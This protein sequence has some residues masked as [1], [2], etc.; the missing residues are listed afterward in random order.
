MSGTRLS[1]RVIWLIFSDVAIIYGGIMLA[2]YLRLGFT[3]S[4]FQLN[5]NNGW[6]KIALAT[7]V[8]LLI[9]YL[10]DLY[11]YTVIANR[12]ELFLRLVLPE[13]RLIQFYFLLNL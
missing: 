10:Y 7:A 3:G 12:R 4:E 1:P 2:L 9:L 11:D 8:C 6:Y 5:E 13:H